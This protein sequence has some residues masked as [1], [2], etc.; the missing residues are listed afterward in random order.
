MVVAAEPGS[1]AARAG[2]RPGD[3]ILEV[4]RQAVDR[5]ERFRELYAKSRE[6]V[7]LLVQREGKTSFVVVRK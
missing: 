5:L 4:D 6:R 7:L 3:V 1:S 2:L